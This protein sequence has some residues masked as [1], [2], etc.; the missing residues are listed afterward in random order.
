MSRYWD[1]TNQRHR[2]SFEIFSYDLRGQ[3][4]VVV[5]RI[6]EQL[7]QVDRHRLAV[8]QNDLRVNGDDVGPLMARLKRTRASRILLFEKISYAGYLYLYLYP[9]PIYHEY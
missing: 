3:N 4:F 1:E 9:I 5:G 6:V 8:V 2:S 7:Q